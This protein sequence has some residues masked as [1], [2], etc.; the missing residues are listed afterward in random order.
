MEEFYA[1]LKKIE[2]LTENIKFF[3]TASY[4]ID[5]VPDNLREYIHHHE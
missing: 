2:E 4:D 3:M 5:K 1:F